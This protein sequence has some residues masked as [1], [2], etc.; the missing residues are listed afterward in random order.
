MHT[1][2]RAGGIALGLLLGL[3]VLPAHAVQTAV[4]VSS[5]TYETTT[6]LIKSETVEPDDAALAV[7]TSYTYDSY[8]NKQYIDL[9][10]KIRLPRVT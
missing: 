2:T 5:F 8:G 9:P 3:F 6:G 7:T 10:P 1:A 4:R